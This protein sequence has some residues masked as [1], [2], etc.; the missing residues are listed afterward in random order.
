MSEITSARI[1]D[2]AVAKAAADPGFHLEREFLRRPQETIDTINIQKLKRANRDLAFES[3]GPSGVSPVAIFQQLLVV[4]NRFSWSMSQF[5]GAPSSMQLVEPIGGRRT[6]IAFSYSANASSDRP[7]SNSMS[8]SIFALGQ[9]RF[10]FPSKSCLS[11][12]RRNKLTASPFLPCTKVSQA[13]FILVRAHVLGYERM[14]A[15]LGRVYHRVVKVNS[16]LCSRFI[17]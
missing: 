15:F 12:T 14:V 16:V 17:V 10:A 2:Y 9:F 7:I 8:P 1:A 13:C 4:D 3:S 6:F 5:R 11:A